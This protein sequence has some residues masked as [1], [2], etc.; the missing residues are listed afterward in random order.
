MGIWRS[1]PVVRPTAARLAVLRIGQGGLLL[2][3]SRLTPTQVAVFVNLN[4]IVA[5]L[6]AILLL[7]ERRSAL[8]LVGFAAVVIGVLLVNWPGHKT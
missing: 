5:A 8:F 6:L 4:P 7:D 3:L 1:V 2:A